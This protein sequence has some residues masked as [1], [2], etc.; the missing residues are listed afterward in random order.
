V[1][2]A[3][4][5]RDAADRPGVALELRETRGGVAERFRLILDPGTYQLLGVE[6]ISGETGPDGTV[7]TS[8]AG[9][10]KERSTVVLRAEWT[11]AEPVPPSLT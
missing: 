3:G 2:N 6:I 9:R 1:V 5:A 7:D 10:F 8:P 4:P 11:D